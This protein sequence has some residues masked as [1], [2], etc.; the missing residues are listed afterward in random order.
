MDFYQELGYL[1]LGSRLRRLS[2]QFLSAVNAVYEQQGIPFDASWFPVF[3]LLEQRPGL[4]IRQL[5]NT[6]HIS[7][8]AASQLT[9]QLQQKGLVVLQVSTQDGRRRQ[10]H[11]TPAG[12]ALLARVKP[13]W[14]AIA[15]ALR[16]ACDQDKSQYLLQALTQ[17]E[18]SLQQQPLLNRINHKLAQP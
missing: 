5:S 9:S 7:H 8:S 14:Q 3:Y 18:A 17:L 2:E 12:Q 11:F 6:L 1:V 16:E 10:L 15:P 4:S 13:I